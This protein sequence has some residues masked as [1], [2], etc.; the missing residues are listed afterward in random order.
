MIL[1]WLLGLGVLILL[2]VFVLAFR[3][4]GALRQR[5]IGEAQR[6]TT[7]SEAPT[8][9]QHPAASDERPAE[10]GSLTAEQIRRQSQCA[11][12]ERFDAFEEIGVDR[13]LAGDFVLS[14]RL[15]PVFAPAA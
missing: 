5:A 10:A 3:V 2:A 13:A 4:R 15:A 7:E 9:D 14:D 1:D 11:A 12:R 8:V 6:G